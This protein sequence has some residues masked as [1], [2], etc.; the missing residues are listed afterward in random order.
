MPRFS[1][2]IPAYK[3]IALVQQVEID[4]EDMAAAVRKANQR[5][6][7]GAITIEDFEGAEWVDTLGWESKEAS[8]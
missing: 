8:E 3:T 1:V 2:D 4:A 6:E 7:S 5:V